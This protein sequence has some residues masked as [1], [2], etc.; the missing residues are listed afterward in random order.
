MDKIAAGI[1][2]K[3]SIVGFFNVIISGAVILHGLSP[4]MDR[5]APQ[6]FYAK[7][8]LDND[9]EKGIIIC[10]MCYILGCALQG[11]Q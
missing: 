10:L 2:D 8:G 6:L 4:V 5:Y 7:L 9:L 11:I 1:I 3:L